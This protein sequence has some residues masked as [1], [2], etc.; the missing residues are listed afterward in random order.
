M[1]AD[2]PRVVSGQRGAQAWRLGAFWFGIQV[3]WTSV[4]GVVL[5]DRVSTLSATGA[6]ARYALIAAVGAAVAAVIQVAAGVL[7]DRQRV[8]TGHR[9]AFYRTGVI[10]AVPAVIGVTIAPSL[11]WLWV[12]MLALQV[13]M[14]VAGG[15]YQAIV[16][17]YVEPERVGRASSW[18]SVYQF[19]GS[20]VGLALTIVLHGALLGF[21]LATCLLVSW[22]A[23]DAYARTLPGSRET[24]RPLRLDTNAWIVIASRALIN[25]GFY[26][27][28]GFLFFFVRESLG[29]ADARTTTGILFLAFT[30]AGVGGAAAAGVPADRLDKRIVVTIACLAIGIAVGAFAAAPTFAV[31]LVCA[32]A[33]GAAWGAFFT[34]DWAI[35]YAVLPSAALA[36]AMG[37]WN[38]AAAVAQVAAPAITQP[39]VSFYDA[40]SAGLGP[41]VA[42]M[43]VI[44]EFALGTALLWRVRLAPTG[45][46]AG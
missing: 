10:V 1:L 26:T 32:I 40:R 33:A 19:S 6:V 36:S 27:L 8:R 5:Q 31:A 35:A 44:V 9:L 13:G 38:L 12:A 43:C 37:V 30:I 20:V 39:V 15:P 24:V 46:R 14:N 11:A 21:A 28:F 17:D 16:G 45:R 34:A 3:V 22:W 25:I 41:R 2:R 18:M 7:S 4:L 23:T 42:L 29:V